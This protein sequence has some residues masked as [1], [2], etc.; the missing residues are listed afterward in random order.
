[1]F[2][3]FRKYH[4][5]AEYPPALCGP[6]CNQHTGTCFACPDDHYWGEY[7]NISCRTIDKD[8][9]R[10][11]SAGKQ[12]S[13]CNQDVSS[14]SCSSNCYPNCADCG[15]NGYCYHCLQG[16]WG[17]NCTMMCLENCLFCNKFNGACQRCIDGLWGENCTKLCSFNNCSHCNLRNGMCETCEIGLWGPSCENKCSAGCAD[18]RCEKNTGACEICKHLYWGVSCNLTCTI[19]NCES[20]IAC[21]KA[22]GPSC[23]K[24]ING[25]WGI[26]CS[27]DC[28][29]NCVN[30]CETRS[31]DC[32]VI[33]VASKLSTTQIPSEANLK[34]R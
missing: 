33:T 20:I 13:I 19:D 6:H 12:C 11:Q 9:D 3:S 15:D 16:F 29:E 8:C 24:C 10:C 34:C 7:C 17:R 26:H 22:I 14:S 32:Q 27:N 18:T 30:D 25:K 4:T 31:G 21:S 5:N 1:M 2:V 28:P 23:Y